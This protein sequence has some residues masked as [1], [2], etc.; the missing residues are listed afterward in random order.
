M[1]PVGRWE[2]ASVESPLRRADTAS[3]SLAKTGKRSP[4]CRSK[5]WWPNLPS[6]PIDEATRRIEPSAEA[7]ILHAAEFNGSE[8]PVLLRRGDAYFLNTYTPS[9]DCWNAF[10]PLVL[11]CSL[12]RGVLFRS[13]SHS[14]TEAGLSSRN[15]DQWGVIPEAELP[16]DRVRLVAPPELAQPLPVALP[17]SKTPLT[18]RVLSGNRPTIP[19]P[20]P[21]SIPPHITL[22]PGEVVE[23]TR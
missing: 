10:M 2:P 11:G 20:D 21:G 19:F 14:V 16:V 13:A 5:P 9:E 7:E 23:L 3:P 12:Q 1:W 17:A 15:E 8:V 6:G 4:A 22:Q 18:L